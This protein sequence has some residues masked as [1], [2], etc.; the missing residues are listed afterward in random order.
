MILH[1]RFAFDWPYNLRCEQ[2]PEESH[3]LCVN[4]PIPETTSP[5][6]L[7]TTAEVPT[8]TTTTTTEK[9]TTKPV[10]PKDKVDLDNCQ[11]SCTCKP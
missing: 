2:F 6:P 1:F 3:D 5:P 7:S 11:C 4:V 9:V 8:T 10:T